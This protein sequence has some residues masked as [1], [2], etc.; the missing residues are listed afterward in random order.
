MWIGVNDLWASEFTGRPRQDQ[1]GVKF[2]GQYYKGA[3][4]RRLRGQRKNRIYRNVD[5]ELQEATISIEA[6]ALKYLEDEVLPKLPDALYEHFRKDIEFRKE[7]GNF[8]RLR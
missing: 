2:R 8:Y 6:D 4:L 3:F 7:A 1:S 5:G